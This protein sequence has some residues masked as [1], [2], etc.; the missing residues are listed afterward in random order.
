VLT[1]YDNPFSPFA[2]KVRMVLRFKGL[3]YRSV[4]ALAL[5]QHD[6]LVDVN[7]RAEVPVLV[8]G[9]IT[10][11]DSS[12]IVCYLEDRF[13][14]PTVLPD[15]CER[16]AKARRWQR[17]ADTVLDAIIHDI[18]IWT[19][20][21]H[22]RSD[23]PPEGLIDAGRRELHEILIDLEGSIDASGFVCAQ[24]SIADFSL[25]PHISSLKPLAILLDEATHP[26]LL[27]WNRQVRMQTAVREDLEYVKQCAIEKF[28]SGQSPYEGEKIVW[29]GDRIE[30]LLANGFQDW[31]VS[32]LELGRAVVPR[33]VSRRDRARN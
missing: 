27:R 13:P 15:G 16:R 32:E 11:T 4:D 25:F 21:T 20:P 8:D 28:G 19:W 29:R 14:K 17:V 22:H 31:F 2:R 7:P 18:S 33:W 6:R 12:D 10:V 9:A 23:Q 24:L 5:D 30:W 1:L 26:N 3:K